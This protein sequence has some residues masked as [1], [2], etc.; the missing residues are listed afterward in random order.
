VK[1]VRLLLSPHYIKYGLPASRRHRVAPYLSLSLHSFI[2]DIR[3]LHWLKQ[4]RVVVPG[5]FFQASLMCGCKIGKACPM[6]PQI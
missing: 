2:T 4:A 3:S 5:H 6:G 1:K